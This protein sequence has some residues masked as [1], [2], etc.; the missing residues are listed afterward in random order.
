MFKKFTTETA[1]VTAGIIT[2]AATVFNSERTIATN[3]K[4]ADEKLSALEDK[5]DLL[6]NQMNALI[7]KSNSTSSPINLNE[8]NEASLLPTDLLELQASF[9]ISIVLFSIATFSALTGLVINYY[10]NLHEKNG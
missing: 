2:A 4:I 5:I 9:S 10:T 8:A 7:V 1:I 3:N 6:S